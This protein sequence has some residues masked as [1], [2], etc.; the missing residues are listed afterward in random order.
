M[1]RTAG[2]VAERTKAALESVLFAATVVQLI[3]HLGVSKQPD[4]V[5]SA[6]FYLGGILEEA[7][8]QIE[9]AVRAVEVR[10]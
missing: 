6:L 5:D 3:A 4:L 10:P 2:P 7:Y 1:I 8:G 9:E